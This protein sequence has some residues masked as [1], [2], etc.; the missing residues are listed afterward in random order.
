MVTYKY[1][2][3]CGNIGIGIIDAVDA[4]VRECARGI[5]LVEA[6]VRKVDGICKHDISTRHERPSR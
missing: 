3:I 4:V 6:V 5:A 2:S 1:A